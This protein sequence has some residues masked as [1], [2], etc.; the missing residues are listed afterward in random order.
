MEQTFQILKLH[1]APITIEDEVTVNYRDKVDLH[2]KMHNGEVI[3]VETEGEVDA[4]YDDVRLNYHEEKIL[5]DNPNSI[6][7]DTVKL[8]NPSSTAFEQVRDV[9]H[10]NKTQTEYEQN[11]WVREHDLKLQVQLVEWT[12]SLPDSSYKMSKMVLIPNKKVENMTIRE[13]ASWQLLK[14]QFGA[15]YISEAHFSD[16]I[17]IDVD[18]EEWMDEGD[19]FYPNVLVDGIGDRAEE[20]RQELERQEIVEQIR[21]EH[22]E[23]VDVQFDPY[24]FMDARVV[25]ENTGEKQRF[26]KKVVY[27]DGEH[28]D[29][30]DTAILTY[31]VTVD[32]DGSNSEGTEEIVT[33]R[34]EAY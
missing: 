29:E 25:A 16:Q 2:I 15:V 6:E 23:L 27:N 20:I 19:V 33:E 22:E 13:E 18:D 5:L 17:V 30:S 11:Q 3:T 14:E 4:E 31:Y 21:D 26:A 1:Q 12:E 9:I 28:D 32:S 24:R 10:Q 34:R 8:T 7:E